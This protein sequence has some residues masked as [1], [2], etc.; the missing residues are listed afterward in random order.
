M[1]ECAK[2]KE[3]IARAEESAVVDGWT[4]HASC[5]DGVP[6]PKEVEERPHEIVDS[7]R[8]SLDEGSRRV[9]DAD[10][11]WV[12][13]NPTVGVLL[14]LFLGGVGVHRYYLRDWTGLLY[15]VFAWTFIPILVA[16]VEAFDM[17][18]RVR[19]YNQAQAEAILARIRA[20]SPAP[21]E[22]IDHRQRV[23][24]P[25]CAELILPAAK[26]CRFCGARL[27]LWEIEE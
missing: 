6:R 11:K 18:R 27:G 25:E 10:Y 23:P 4:Y 7:I 8:E 21:S 14:A 22:P 16:L 17:P 2:C 20:K 1:T 19:E 9:F 13:K 12:E 24:C 5:L 15:L 26:K 3:W